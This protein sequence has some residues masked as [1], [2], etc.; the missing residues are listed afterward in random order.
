MLLLPPLTLNTQVDLT[1]FSPAGFASNELA[2][3]Q[4]T[5][6]DVLVGSKADAA[7]PGAAAALQDWADSAFWPH[8]AAVVTSTCGQLDAG[9]LQLPRATG[10]VA[11]QLLAAAQQS[12]AAA[13]HAA[14][15][16]GTAVAE[17]PLL[18]AGQPQQQ[19]QQQQPNG[20]SVNLSPPSAL[21]PP[22]APAPEPAPRR[23]TRVIDAPPGRQAIHSCGWLFAESDQFDAARLLGVLRA[24][25]SAT[26]VV[27]RVKGVF[28][29]GE[30]RWVSPVAA[31]TQWGLMEGQIEGQSISSGVSSDSVTPSQRCEQLV[32]QPLC[33]R[34][35]S[36]VQVLL[37]PPSCTAAAADEDIDPAAAAAAAAADGRLAS[38]TA[39]L[40]GALGSGSMQEQT[41]SGAGGG[42]KPAVWQLLE[43]AWLHCLQ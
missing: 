26:A 18:H 11:M 32:L 17:S 30:R 36:V 39:V 1:S 43:A 25:S 7:T 12:D 19:Q 4:A 2:L 16:S 33:Y 5:I 35:P 9:L 34:G 20:S 42:G 23:P 15:R 38:L 22:P 8:K 24:L 6:A 14:Q 21:Q 3:D 40:S 27:A 13:A 10:H 37:W 41:Q 28:R 31:G 29:T